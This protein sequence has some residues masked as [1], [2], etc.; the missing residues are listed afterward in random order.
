MRFVSFILVII[1]LVLFPVFGHPSQKVITFL[2][3]NDLHSHLMPFAPELDF[4]P[5]ETGV[6]DTIGGWSR[7][8]EVFKAERKKRKNPVFTVD[9]GDFTMGTLFHMLAR[10]KSFELRLMHEMGYD[11]VTLGNHEF[12]MFP[13]GLAQIINTAQQESQLP[14]IVFSSAVF[15]SKSD[16][17]D[18]LKQVFEQ[19]L[20]KP[21]SIRE[22][23]GVK[24]GFY[25]IMGKIAAEEAPFAAPVTFRDPVQ[26]SR[27]MVQ[28]LREQEKVDIVVCLSHSGLEMGASSEDEE[29]AAAVQGIDLIVSGHSHTLLQEPLVVNET[30]IVQAGK[31]GQA[32]GVLDIE[33]DGEKVALKD[34]ELIAVEDSIA[35]DQ[36]IQSRIDEFIA[37][38]DAHILNKHGLSYW[39]IIGKAGFD[40]HIREQESSLGNLLADA[41]RWFVN[42]H[43]Y[44]LQDPASRVRIAIKANGVIRADILQGNTGQLA[45]ADVFRALPLGIGMDEDHSPGYPL[46][47]CYIYAYELKRVLE[48]ITTVYPLR[49]S[50][51]FLQISGVKFTY[52]PWR[53]L[54]DRVTEIWLETE[55]GNYQRLDYSRSNKALY[56]VAANIYEASFLQV[57]GSFTWNILD[58]VPKDRE[59]QPIESLLDFR[60][61]VEPS[62]PG[63]QELK[64][65]LA[66]MA[67]ISGFEDKTGDGLADVPEKY[68]APQGRIL[69]QPS[70]NPIDL[71]ARGTVLTWAAFASILAAAAIISLVLLLIKKIFY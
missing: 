60:V 19:G 59:G 39:E 20:V 44:D 14:E 30:I 38:I 54:F 43:D 16:K 49:G 36:E 63:I 42:K 64:E 52:N 10:E 23:D 28:V 25:G 50:S 7:I 18:S 1:V 12:D 40:M 31:Y 17:D 13:D 41:M 61:D 58:I 69:E 15:S 3:T 56:R 34:Y 11:L 67:Y 32:V 45:V 29:I 51:Y 48:V 71:I 37:E 57:I 55:E 65:W 26:V 68:R 21:Y 47:T 53:M 35:V 46:V 4:V 70:L 8:A 22:A 24:I 62:K 27:E 2:H 5:Q 9:S 6:D 33:F 66:V